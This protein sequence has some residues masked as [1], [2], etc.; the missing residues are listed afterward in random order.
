MKP[1]IICAVVKP[2]SEFY[3]HPNMKD[4]T[5]NKCKSCCVDY[6]NHRKVTNPQAVRIS[7]WKRNQ[8]P[9]RRAKKREYSKRNPD[10]MRRLS[11][12]QRATFPEKKVARTAVSNAVR[13]GRLK[14]MPCKVCGVERVE[15]H[16][17]DYAKPLEVVWLCKKH[18]A[19]IH[20]PPPV[21]AL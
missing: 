3:A 15:A 16:H 8:K 18:H 13:D 19:A 5:L 20:H 4:G 9:E 7:E 17:E 6:A 14:K 10:L 12:I 11:A 21:A 1:C 2:L